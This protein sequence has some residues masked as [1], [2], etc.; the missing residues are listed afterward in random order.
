MHLAGHTA[1]IPAMSRVENHLS[2]NMRVRKMLLQ[3]GAEEET[4][5]STKLINKAQLGVT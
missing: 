4:V 1:K 5:A 2:Q 3:Q